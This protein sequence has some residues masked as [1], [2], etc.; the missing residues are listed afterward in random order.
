MVLWGEYFIN[1]EKSNIVYNV[2]LDT[3]DD[4]KL[5]DEKL[6]EIITKKLLKVSLNTE[7]LKEKTFYNG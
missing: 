1:Y 4:V 7:N 6:E 3:K 5:D 2:V